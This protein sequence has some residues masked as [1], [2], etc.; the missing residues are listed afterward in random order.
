MHPPIPRHPLDSPEVAVVPA[1]ESHPVEPPPCVRGRRR[2]Q[3]C[4]TRQR[5]GQRGGE[6]SLG[7]LDPPAPTQIGKRR[8]GGGRGDKLGENPNSGFCQGCTHSARGTATNCAIT[9]C[10]TRPQTA[11]P[12]LGLACAPCSC[13][14]PRKDLSEDHPEQD[15]QMRRVM[16]RDGRVRCA[17]SR[18]CAGE[19]FAVVCVRQPGG[20]PHVAEATVTHRMRRGVPRLSIQH[21]QEGCA[22]VGAGAARGGHAPLHAHTTFRSDCLEGGGSEGERG[23]VKQQRHIASN[24]T[25]PTCFTPVC[26][27]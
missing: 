13:H 16:L 20:L 7:C 10:A 15:A 5:Y 9:T 27:A 12:P 24:S 14:V 22:R 8:P 1:A 3:W 21:A 18:R 26:V 25:D 11:S 4:R 6:S 19:V 23:V 2:R 17:P